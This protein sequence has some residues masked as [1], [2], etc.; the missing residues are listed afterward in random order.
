MLCPGSVCGKASGRWRFL[1]AMTGIETA[2]IAAFQQAM[3]GDLDAGLINPQLFW[4]ALYV[5]DPFSGAVGHG[6]EITAKG[7]HAIA[8]DPAFFYQD[9]VI[10]MSRQIG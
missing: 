10:R 9:G 8:S 5:Q 4:M 1:I 6:I 3:A 2:L 7:D